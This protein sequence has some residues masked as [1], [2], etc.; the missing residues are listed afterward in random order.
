MEVEAGDADEA[1]WSNF[2]VSNREWTVSSRP[3]KMA[4][5]GKE[6]EWR[7]KIAP[8]FSSPSWGQS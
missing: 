7:P 1:A 6:E 2:R 5:T 4:Q 3:L 8:T